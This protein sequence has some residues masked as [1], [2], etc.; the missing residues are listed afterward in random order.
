[1]QARARAGA[2]VAPQVEVKVP[3]V[4]V[5]TGE[6]RNQ[7]LQIPTTHEEM[8]GLMAQREALTD[9]LEELKDQR[10][11]VIQQLRSAPAEARSGLQQQLSGLTEQMVAVQGDLN[12]IGREI[13]HAAP[14]LIAMSHEDPSPPDE[15]GTFQDGLFLGAAG[16][17]LTMSALLVL[18]TLL[19]KRFRRDAPMRA[20]PAAESERLQRLEHGMEAIAIEVERISE[21]QRYV[22]KLMSE[23][24]SPESTP[25]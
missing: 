2:D 10:N 6:G 12:R 18:V 24:R 23:Q 17:F 9:Q 22:T 1:M 21:G 20:L 4:T 13:S 15:P 14:S 11:D 16:V 19:W 5:V 8:M 7:V 25:R 3:T